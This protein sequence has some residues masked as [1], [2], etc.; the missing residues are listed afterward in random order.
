M[1]CPRCG[2]ENDYPFSKCFNCACD[3]IWTKKEM[4]KNFISRV[5]T[6]AITACITAALFVLFYK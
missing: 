4:A 3:L 6:A 2:F 1:K 5:L